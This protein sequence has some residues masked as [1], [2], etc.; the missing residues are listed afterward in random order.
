MSF[1]TFGKIF[2]FTTF[3]ESHGPAI[4]VVVDGVPAGLE[5]GEADIQKELD[6]RRPGQ[7]E[8]TSPRGEP[9]RAE[10]ISGV[11]EGKT[12]G[13]PVA[14]LVRNEDARSGDY[15]RIK[16]VFRPG[17][18]DY[19]YEKKFRVRDYR[20]GGRSSARETAMRVAAGAIAKKFLSE[21]G[22][23][24]IGFTRE[25]AGIRAEKTDYSAIE[26]NPV[27][28]P[29]MSA[30]KKME[31]IVLEAKGGGDSA[32]G[33]VEV[34]ASGVPAGLGE[35]VYSRLDAKLA[36]ALMG[37]N[38]VKGVEIGSG[39]ASARMRGSE[40]NDEIFVSGKKTGFKTNNSGGILGGISNGDDIVV[41]IA[42]KPASSILREQKTVDRKGKLARL[43]VEGRHDPCLC[44]RAVPVA[45][46]M[47][48][49]VLMDFY[50]IA[51]TRKK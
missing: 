41:R 43:V 17:H 45:E 4:G 36:E 26:K 29:D 2:S 1:N 49:C 30:A 34:I 7:S 40:N 51:R 11:F 14:I 47:V 23:R 31:K 42:V 35:P 32:G 15:S 33:I 18:A 38:A 19:T 48:A 50:L 3:G 12:T 24:V 39:F 13:M 27:R 22:I 10:I 8:V 6:R 37:I 28:A 25:I 9:D 5:L 20:G 21:K 44:P 46:A 16:D